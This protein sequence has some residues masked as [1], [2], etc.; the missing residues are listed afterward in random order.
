[1]CTATTDRTV[2]GSALAEVWAAAG[3]TDKKIIVARRKAA[4]FGI[5]VSAID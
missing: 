2:E 3:L 5:D 1:M 4:F